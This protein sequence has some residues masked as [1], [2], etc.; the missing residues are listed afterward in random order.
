MFFHYWT[1]ISISLPQSGEKLGKNGN[2]CKIY[3]QKASTILEFVLGRD[4]LY[5]NCLHNFSAMWMSSEDVNFDQTI[6][7][8]L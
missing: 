5:H 4:S 7:S 6:F 2:R 1:S 8:T 3:R